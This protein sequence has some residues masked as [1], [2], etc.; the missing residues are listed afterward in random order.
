MPKSGAGVI[1]RL[2]VAVCESA[3][4]V[5]VTV[6]VDVAAAVAVVVLTVNVEAPDAIAEK[7]AVA[8]VGNPVAASV[9]GPANPLLGI[10]CTE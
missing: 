8:P 1:T 9:T 6:S 10:I 2:A 4:L 5:P 7:L 3:P